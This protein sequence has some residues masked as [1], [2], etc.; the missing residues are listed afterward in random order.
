MEWKIVYG[1]DMMTAINRNEIAKGVFFNSIKDNRFKTMKITANMI[2]PL[3]KENASANALLCGVLSHSC[4]AY[5]DFTELSRKLSSLYG[6]DLGT[7]VRKIGDNQILRISASA[8]DDRYVFDGDSVALELSELLCNVIFEPNLTNNAFSETDV[9]QEKRQ[10]LDVIDSEFNDKRIY[11]N[12]QLIKNMCSDEVFGI[13]RF[14][15]AE[16]IKECSP[17]SLFDTWK[18]LLKT[19]RFEI[20]YVGESS[21]KKAE[22]VFANAFNGIDRQ[23]QFVNTEVVREASEPKHIIEEMELS[24]SKLVMGFRAGTSI[25]DE[26]VNA[27]R[28]MCA[29]LGG[30]ASSKLFCNVR[31]KQSLCYYCSSSYDRVKGIITV[32]S[33]VEGDNIKKAEQG[34]LN[35]IEEMKKGNITDFEMNATKMAI[36]NSF[37]STNDTVGGIE[38][39]YINQ[40]FD[41]K[42]QSIEEISNAIN[43]VTKEQVIAAA[44]KITLDT[45]YVLKNK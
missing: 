3:T 22:E 43:A 31:E 16:K 39:W 38:A 21:S 45:V 29:I 37:Y 44:Q 23:P 17:Q 5:P 19:A 24:Q 25:P 6:A 32:D 26:D 40:L 9:E 13:K 27:T 30:T 2:V 42:F 18:N 41:E 15:T 36:V 10:L 34:I 7:S 33:G 1:V 12:G 8:L 28:L 35:E 4:K 20:M 14:G 11:A